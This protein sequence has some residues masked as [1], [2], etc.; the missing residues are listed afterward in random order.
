[1]VSCCLIQMLFRLEMFT[2]RGGKE[3]TWKEIF[4]AVSDF[5]YHFS[6]EKPKFEVISCLLGEKVQKHFIYSSW[7]N[8]LLRPKIKYI[9]IECADWAWK[10]FKVSY[11]RVPLWKDWKIFLL[12]TSRNFQKILPPVT[13][14]KARPIL[15]R[16][17]LLQCRHSSSDRSY[18]LDFR[19]I[20]DVCEE[21]DKKQ[22][23]DP[24]KKT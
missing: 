11:S 15:T 19:T 7:K 8:H 13:Y 4:L 23:F 20:H 24:K 22:S 12:K 16:W 1:M 14:D 2:P 18:P 5:L 17:K 3:D 10:I 9:P 21:I 6:F